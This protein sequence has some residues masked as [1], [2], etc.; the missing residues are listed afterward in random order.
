MKRR[1][2]RKGCL[3]TGKN[4]MKEEGKKASFK[5]FS[6]T[7]EFAGMSGTLVRDHLKRHAPAATSDAPGSG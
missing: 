1:A 6:S 7:P 5:V 4:Q 3:H 2:L